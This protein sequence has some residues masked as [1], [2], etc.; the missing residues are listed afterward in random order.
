MS[1]LVTSLA[2]FHSQPWMILDS[3]LLKNLTSLHV[4][5]SC[6][7]QPTAGSSSPSD[8]PPILSPVHKPNHKA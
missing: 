2:I 5:P 8:L 4:L 1:F 6:R 7:V 3:E